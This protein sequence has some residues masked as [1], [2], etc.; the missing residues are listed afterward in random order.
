MRIICSIEGAHDY[1]TERITYN[2]HLSSEFLL[3]LLSISPH[4][5]DH[6]I[7]SSCTKGLIIMVLIHAKSIYGAT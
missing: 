2:C 7:I 6:H 5:N 3:Y 4:S 1:F